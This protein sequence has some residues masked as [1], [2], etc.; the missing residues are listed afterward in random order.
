MACVEECISERKG[1]KFEEG[2]NTNVKLDIYKRFGKSVE[3]KKYLHE[4]VRRFLFKFRS[5]THGL[6][7]ELGRHRGREGKTECSLIGNECENVSHVLWEC[8]AYS[9][10]TRDRFMKKLQELLE[11]DYEDFE[12]LENVEKLSYVLGSELWE[13]KFDGLHGLVKEY[14]VEMWEI[15]KHKLYDVTQGLVY[16]SILSFHLG[17]GVIC[18]VRMVS[19][20][21]MVKCI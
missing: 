9:S 6:N 16:N 3:F 13:S 8:S 2:L 12:S 21:I 17:R 1:R 10:S 11:D 19:L 14:I 20:V 7:E 18:S 5:G 15:R 4:E